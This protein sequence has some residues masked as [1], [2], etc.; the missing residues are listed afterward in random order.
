[1]NRL[2][3]QLSER[4]NRAQTITFT[5]NGK[6]IT[7]HPGDT[8]ASALA[9]NG[10]QVITRSFTNTEESG[11]TYTLSGGRNTGARVPSGKVEELRSCR[12]VDRPN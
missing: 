4:L 10:V 2:P 1:M 12:M 7:A 3:P 11:K 9:A 8:I 5:F 6:P